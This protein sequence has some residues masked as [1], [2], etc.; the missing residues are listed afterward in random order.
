M[1]DFVSVIIPTRNRAESTLECLT[2][3]YRSSH[4]NLEVIVVDNASTDNTG[5]LI[6]EKYPSVKLVVSEYNRM[7]VGGRN[8][9]IEYAKGDFLLFIDSD[10]EIDPNMISALVSVAKSDH[11]IGLLGPKIYCYDD[12]ERLWCAGADISLVTGKT[13]H[14][15]AKQIDVGQFDVMREVGHMPNVFMVS[16][17][18]LIKAG[19]KLR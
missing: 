2:S 16:R 11:S 15:G 5:D 4:K 18:A 7:A 3:V 10:N 17:K 19:G 13:T 14:L 8:L 12:R 1:N 6:R 9:G